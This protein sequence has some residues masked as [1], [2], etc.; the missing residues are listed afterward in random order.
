MES[1]QPMTAP[2]ADCCRS[3]LPRTIPLRQDRSTSRDNDPW[4]HQAAPSLTATPRCHIVG[5][6]S[7]EMLLGSNCVR[8]PTLGITIEQAECDERI[9]EITCAAGMKTD[10]LA[11]RLKGEGAIGQCIK[12]SELNRA[13]ESLG[14]PKRVGQGDDALGGLRAAPVPY[15]AKCAHLISTS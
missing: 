13:K 4:P 7:D 6:S 12:H 2:L 10:P 3:S 9:E 5:L 14:F 8:V 1:A 11:Q 15:V